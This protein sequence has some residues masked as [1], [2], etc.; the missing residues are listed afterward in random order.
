ML[1]YGYQ[2][3]FSILTHYSIFPLFP[4]SNPMLFHYFLRVHQRLKS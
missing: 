2:I 3:N 1:E 4:Y